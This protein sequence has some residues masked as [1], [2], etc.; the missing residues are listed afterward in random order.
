[1]AGCL[2]GNTYAQSGQVATLNAASADAKANRYADACSELAKLNTETNGLQSVDPVILSSLGNLK[3]PETM[4]SETEAFMASKD[5][6]KGCVDA[7]VTALAY[8]RKGDQASAKRMLTMASMAQ[9]LVTSNAGT[10][11][12]NPSA[13]SAAAPGANSNCPSDDVM[14][15]QPNTVQRCFDSLIAQG[16]AYQQAGDLNAAK[17]TYQRAQVVN[18]YLGMYGMANGNT[19]TGLLS[20]VEQAQAPPPSP[21]QYGAA[22]AIPTGQYS[23]Y[24][25]ATVTF[26]AGG[27]GSVAMNAPRFFGY[28]WIFDAHHYANANQNDRGS[29]SVGSDGKWTNITGPFQSVKATVVWT[30][31]GPFHRPAIVI[32]WPNVHIGMA[33]QK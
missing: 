6:A 12:A 7:Y 8:V 23:C 25:G 31:N 32:N 33:C 29:Y 13:S 3:P 19:V 24:T 9:A 27:I 2:A 4:E 30:E 14:K 17:A 5:Y 11:A 15:K 22:G 20:S 1:M 16:K 21:V 10:P 26:T 18:G 28:L